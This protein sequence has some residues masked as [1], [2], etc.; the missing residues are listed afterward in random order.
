M[1]NALIL[2][3]AKQS[4][5]PVKDVEYYWDV[6]KE[7][8][9]QKFGKNQKAPGYWAY[10]NAI[11][12]KRLGLR[13]SFRE[14]SDWFYLTELKKP[15]LG[16]TMEFNYQVK[17]AFD[18]EIPIEDW[19]SEGKNLVG[20]LMIGDSEYRIRLEPFTFPVL[21]KIRNGVNVAFT[22]IID[23]KEIEEITHDSGYTASKIIGAIVNGLIKKLSDYYFEAVTFIATNAVDQRMRVYNFIA[24]RFRTKFGVSIP[25]IKIPT[26]LLTIITTSNISKQA[27]ED[28]KKEVSK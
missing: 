23:G 12:R 14:F 22:K 4:K 17:E 16:E 2:K 7:A 1:P 13:E 26:G 9:D 8:A 5:A 20:K 10:V 6:A 21:G 18:T 28:I 11:V 25:D 15:T 3:Y 27:V 19:R 24:N